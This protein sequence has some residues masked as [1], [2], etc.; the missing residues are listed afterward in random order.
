MA[1]NNPNA[2]FDFADELALVSS[3]LL[4]YRIKNKPDLSPAEQG[5]LEDLEISL[6]KATNKVRALGITAL[7]MITDAARK[8]LEDAN[9]EAAA[10]LRRIKKAERALDIATS[11]LGV[12]LAAIAGQPAG[13]VTAI[14]GLVET[15]S[16]PATPKLAPFARRGGTT[17]KT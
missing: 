11:V 12:A 15:V 7:G 3:D 8:D 17:G 9:D 6:D 1:T 5:K 10:L 16:V 13:I 14:K 2:L 4:R